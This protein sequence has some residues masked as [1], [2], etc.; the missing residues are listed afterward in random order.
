MFRNKNIAMVIALLCWLILRF[1]CSYLPI[2]IHLRPSIDRQTVYDCN[3]NK[4]DIFYN[5]S[6]FHFSNNFS[7]DRG[8]SICL[9]QDFISYHLQMQRCIIILGLIA[10]LNYF[11]S[12]FSFINTVIEHR[13]YVQFYAPRFVGLPFKQQIQTSLAF[14][15]CL[16][17]IHLMTLHNKHN[18]F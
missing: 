4:Q 5:S 11:E 12:L 2:G 8:V 18:I 3:N 13:L 10:E 7:V 17:N 1:R 15:D 6:L 9:L 14:R 16:R